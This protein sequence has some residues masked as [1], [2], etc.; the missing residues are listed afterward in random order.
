LSFIFQHPAAPERSTLSLHDALPIYRLGDAEGA[1]D[2]GDG[3]QAGDGRAE[4]VGALVRQGDVHDLPDEEGRDDAGGGAD[5]DEGED[6][7]EGAAVGA[8][9]GEDAAH[10]RLLPGAQARIIPQ[11]SAAAA[12]EASPARSAVDHQ[13]PWWRATRCAAAWARGRTVTRSRFTWCGAFRA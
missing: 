12:A 4:H 2:D 1:G 13:T 5:H 3:D 11:C 6:H 9:Q 8:E 7:G 10:I